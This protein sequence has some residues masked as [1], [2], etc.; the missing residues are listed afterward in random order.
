M[1]SGLGNL[2]RK[3]RNILYEIQ[4]HF[5]VT[6]ETVALYI[7]PGSGSIIAQGLIGALV[8]AGLFLKVYWAKFRLKLQ[9]L[10]QK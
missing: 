4:D 5:Y 8:G 7:D 1:E 2:D 6:I 10:Q 9:T 3:H